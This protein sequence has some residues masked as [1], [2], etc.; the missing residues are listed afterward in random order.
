M[1]QPFLAEVIS[2]SI[3]PLHV[4]NPIRR[5]IPSA[6]FFQA[7]IEG[8][9]VDSQ[10]VTIRYPGHP[11]HHH[12]PYDHLVIAVGSTTDLSALPGVAEHA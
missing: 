11:H 2:G 5:L 9:H 3:E 12:I 8:I 4:V 7:E 1:F 10:N 6:N